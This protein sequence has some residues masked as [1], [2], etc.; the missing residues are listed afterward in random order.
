MLQSNKVKI[1]DIG[2]VLFQPSTKAK[3]LAISMKPFQGIRVAVPKGVSLKRAEQFLHSKAQW[4][5][6]HALKMNRL[7]KMH[8]DV[9]E[10]LARIDHTEAKRIL[11][12][13]L[14]ELAEKYG[15][16]YKRVCIRKQKTRWGSCSAENNISLNVKLLLLPVK[17]MDFIMLHELVHTKVKNHGKDFWTT[18]LAIEPDAKALSSKIKEKSIVLL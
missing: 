18:L 10:R 2:P 13:R 6:K 15:L 9:S 17:L 8:K 5:Q 14:K 4:V 7:E 11:A 3:R 12:A 16:T 1:K